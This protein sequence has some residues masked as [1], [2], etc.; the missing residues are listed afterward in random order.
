ME[1]NVHKNKLLFYNDKK[2]NSSIINNNYQKVIV[3]E[4]GGNTLHAGELTDDLLIDLSYI[5]S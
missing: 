2:K 5:F 4:E 1:V 3:T